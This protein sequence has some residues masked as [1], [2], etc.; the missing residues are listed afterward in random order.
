MATGR[1]NRRSMPPGSSTALVMVTA[2]TGRSSVTLV[3][4][5]DGGHHRVPAP[6]QYPAV[7][8]ERSLVGEGG[9]PWPSST[10]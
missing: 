4:D 2:A 8:P 10:W 3:D 7:Q 9:T 5:L 1:V 6:T